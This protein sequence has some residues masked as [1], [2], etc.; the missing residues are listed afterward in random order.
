MNRATV[1]CAE[2]IEHAL[3]RSFIGDFKYMGN[4]SRAKKEK[5]V[6]PLV[7]REKEEL[8]DPGVRP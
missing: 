7:Q 3:G 8:P 4:Q 6:W 1:T 2:Y 5:T